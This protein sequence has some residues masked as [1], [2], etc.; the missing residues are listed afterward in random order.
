MTQVIRSPKTYDVCVIGSG[1]GGGMAAKILTEGGLTVALVGG[2]RPRES[3]HGLQNV[4]VAVRPA[5]SGSGR[6]RK[7][8]GKFRRIPG[9]QRRVE[10]RRRAVHLGPRREFSVVPFA[11]RGRPHKPLGKNRAAFL[12]HRFQ[13]QNARWHRRRLA[14]LAT[15]IFPLITTRWNRTSAF[16][17]RTKIFP[18]RRTGFFF[19]LPNRAAPN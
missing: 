5:A 17:V 6:W 2:R 15:K 4:S 1:A 11:H 16:S 12:S 8:G 3:G 10:N 7:G 14:N 13:I 9:A 19:R 18:A